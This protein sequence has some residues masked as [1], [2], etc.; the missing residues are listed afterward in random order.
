MATHHHTSNPWGR[1]ADIT[2]P[3]LH[4]TSTTPSIL[5]SSL[6]DVGLLKSTLLP[7]LTINAS[8][9]AVAYTAGRLTDRLDTKDFAWP[10]GPV[11]NAWYAAVFRHTPLFSSS[12]EEGG[13]GGGGVSVATA[14]RALTAADRVLLGGVTLWGGRLL[15]RVASRARARGPRGGDDPRYEAVK[16]QRG[17][18]LGTRWPLAG[19]GFWDWAWLTVYLPEAAFQSVIALT[20]TA[21]FR[22]GL[23]GFT[24][25]DHVVWGAGAGGYAREVVRA[26]AVG[27]FSAGFALEVL[28]DWQLSKFKGK[29]KEEEEEE[30]KGKM[31]REG[32][33]SVVRHPNYLGDALVHYSFPLFLFANNM[34]APISLLGP[35][36]NHFFLRY[37]SGDKENEASQARRYGAG[38]VAK[39]ADFEK[40]RHERNS[41][42]PDLGQI[43]NKWTWVVLGCGAA[44]A[45]AD[46]AVRAML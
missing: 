31:C 21:P 36:A 29:E 32:V 28:A 13:G 12:S 24:G 26:V 38:D 37:V 45:L 5:A 43:R 3:P 35:L 1:G 18:T 22:L 20:V 40:Y 7:S 42:W 27:L 25:V 10:L 15:Y 33:W 19:G 34:L 44:G 39:K 17:L 8:L 2:T 23:G 11:L 41:F 9:A 16:Y 6:V 14:W 4:P 30:G 46:A